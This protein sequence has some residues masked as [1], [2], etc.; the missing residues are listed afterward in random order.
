MSITQMTGVEVS[1]LKS[2]PVLLLI[3]DNQKFQAT[4]H[5]RF[6]SVVVW[7]TMSILRSA[8]AMGHRSRMRLDDGVQV[9]SYR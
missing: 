4:S 7:Y 1:T 9:S 3:R 5:A 6:V 2:T 8:L